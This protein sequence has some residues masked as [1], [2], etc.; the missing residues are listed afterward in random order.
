MST[1]SSEY[2]GDR[3]ADSTMAR[4]YIAYVEVLFV[5]QAIHFILKAYELSD[6]QYKR[7]HGRQGERQEVRGGTGYIKAAC[8]AI[9][10][11][12]KITL[13]CRVAYLLILSRSPF[14]ARQPMDPTL[15]LSDR[16]SGQKT[17]NSFSFFCSFSIK[18]GMAAVNKTKRFA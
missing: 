15:P 3:G 5:L 14:H 6:S 16:A 17:T 11:S 1:C 13:S 8:L 7:K 2:T 18:Y 9:I 10:F 12:A 4:T